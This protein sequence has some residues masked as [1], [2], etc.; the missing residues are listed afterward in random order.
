[1]RKGIRLLQGLFL[2]YI[3]TGIVLLIFSFL[4]Y[5]MAWGEKTIR[6]GIVITYVLS[7]VIGGFYIGRKVKTKRLL[8]GL[9]FGILY[10]SII[11]LVSMIIYPGQPVFAGNFITIV[12][13]CVAGGILGGILS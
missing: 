1:M 7:T 13:I 2:S 5:K 3:I 6:I 11:F 10:V 4:M 12:C 9:L 8:F